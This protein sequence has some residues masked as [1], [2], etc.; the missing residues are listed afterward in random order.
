MDENAGRFDETKSGLIFEQQ[1]RIIG[2]LGESCNFK[3]FAKFYSYLYW[4]GKRSFL[5][6]N[7]T[8]FTLYV[9][10]SDFLVLVLYQRPTNVNFYY[11][12][13]GPMK[14]PL[15]RNKT[16]ITIG[17]KTVKQKSDSISEISLLRA[18]F[19]VRTHHE[20]RDQ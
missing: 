10:F 18:K 15:G 12:T 7:A 14:A 9:L 2:S 5:T 8:D 4:K 20:F 17:L 19:S 11:F 3:I 13:A 1:F 6:T 16:H